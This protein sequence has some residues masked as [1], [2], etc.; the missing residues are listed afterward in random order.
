MRVGNSDVRGSSHCLIGEGWVD[1]KALNVVHQALELA[2][3]NSGLCFFMKK[4]LISISL[5]KEQQ[6]LQ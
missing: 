5:S 1:L 6:F 4:P 3:N 2:S